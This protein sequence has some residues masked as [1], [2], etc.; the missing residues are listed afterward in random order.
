MR[1][2]AR[3]R[4]LTGPCVQLGGR[5]TILRPARGRRVADR[6]RR[7]SVCR[8][9]RILGSDD[10]RPQPPG[11]ARRGGAHRARWPELRR[12]QS[13]RSRDGRNHRAPGAERGDGAHGQL[14]HRGHAVGDPP[15]ARRHGPVAD[16]QVRRLLPRPRR[17]VPGQ[18]RQ[19]C[20]HL[21]RA[22]V[23]RRAQGA[24]RP[25]AHPALQRLRRGHRAV[26]RMRRRHRRPDHR[27]GRRERELPAAAR[28]LP[29]APAVAVHG[30][31]RAAGLRRGDDRVPGRAWRRAGPL[32]RDTRPDHV[33]QGHR[34]RHA[35]RRIRRAA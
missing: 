31:R 33:R 30:P 7:Q 27:A 14:G 9:C 1:V 28:R 32:R 20:A 3:R 18:G 13:A 15:G 2:D 26:R 29:A 8:L 10:R 34:R 22:D 11:R 35:G 4:Q 12:A 24:G 21:W 17:L 19:R 25:H 5:R 6:R 16:R 23:S